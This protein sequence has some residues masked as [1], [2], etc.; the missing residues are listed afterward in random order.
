M[1]EWLYK[2]LP[3]IQYVV[4]QII[5]LIFSNGLTTGDEEQDEK[6]NDFLYSK[7]INGTTNYSVLQNGIKN[8]FIYGKSGIRWLSEKDGIIN[9]DSKHYAC[10]VDENEE[11]YG[12]DDV[13]GYIISIG[14][15]KI[16]EA[17]TDELSFDEAA[18]V[19]NGIVIDKD[20]KIMIISKDDFLN[21]RTNTSKNNG[22]SPLTLDRQ[23]LRLLTTIYERMNYDLAYDGPGRILF[24][25]KNDYAQGG[26]NDI[27][28]SEIINQTKGAQEGRIK[29]AKAEV[30]AIGKKIKES[31]SDNVIAVSSI[32]DEIIHLPRLTKSTEFF[33]YL[34]NEGVIISQLFGVPHTLLGLGKISGNVSMEKIIDNAMLNSVVP[35]REKFATQISGFLADKIGV[36]KIYFDKYEMQQATDENDKR[37]KVVDMISKLKSAGYEK[38]SDRM[39]GMLDDDLDTW[40]VLIKSLKSSVLYKFKKVL[41][42]RNRYDGNNERNSK[43]S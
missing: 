14:C 27:S 7:N 43:R 25:L 9:V 22:E 5:N 21:M 23:R 13:I 10:L 28:T 3:A 1:I 31:T 15:K 17:D 42:R 16:W 36:E 39:A 8:T 30:E 41:N 2:N 34:E 38:L 35:I 24:K 19:K 32:F 26:E 20:N 11:Y 4:D 37:M 33:D 6:L 12:F 18:F 40:G 29:K